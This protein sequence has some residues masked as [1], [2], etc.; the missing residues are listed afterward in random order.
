PCRG[1]PAES[2]VRRIVGHRPVSRKLIS[3]FSGFLLSWLPL[4]RGG[5]KHVRARRRHEAG[6][7]VALEWPD[8]DPVPPLHR[9]GPIPARAGADLQGPDLEFSVSDLRNPERGG[10]R[11]HDN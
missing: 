10:L 1:P 6:N 2:L 11:R 9:P 3:P 4:P 5:G 8:R 7:S